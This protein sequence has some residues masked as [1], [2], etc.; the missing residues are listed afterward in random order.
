MNQY[1]NQRRLSLLVRCVI[2]QMKWDKLE[3][4]YSSNSSS[5]SGSSS[6]SSSIVVKQH[7][8]NM[9][10]VQVF[11]TIR[12][13]GSFTRFSARAGFP[14]RLCPI[15]T[16]TWYRYICLIISCSSIQ[17]NCL[18]ATSRPKTHILLQWVMNIDHSP[19]VVPNIFSFDTS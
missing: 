10:L 11:V 19:E 8:C 17:C 9:S 18:P 1:C 15:L 14:Y 5:S 3:C 2:K 12:N 13:F 16:T 6:S 7:L 4:T